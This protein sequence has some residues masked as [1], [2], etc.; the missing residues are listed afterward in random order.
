MY[1]TVILE[2]NPLH[3][4]AL[5]EILDGYHR[6]ERLVPERMTGSGQ[7]EK[8]L[9]EGR[10]PSVLLTDIVLGEGEETGVELVR[11]LFPAGCGT[12]V[13]YLTGYEEFSGQVWD[14]ANIC[15]LTKPI[16]A[17]E[18]YAALDRALA[19]LEAAEA[20]RLILRVGGALLRVDPG[21]VLYAESDRR[22]L[23]V[24]TDDGVYETYLTMDRLETM[25]PRRFLRCHK[26]FLV[27]PERVGTLAEDCFILTDGSRVPISRAKSREVRKAFLAWLAR[28]F[29][30]AVRR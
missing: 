4:A 22:K 6:R 3:A 1:D 13:I 16:R 29:G 19:Q 8:R 10:R 27:N 21:T 11:R 5:A 15:F 28:D 30:G 9:A 26:S 7:L 23:R 14:T 25:L 20:Q 12:Q 24:Y 18:L 2:N 17:A